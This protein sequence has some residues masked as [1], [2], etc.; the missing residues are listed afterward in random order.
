M[1]CKN[2]SHN[3]TVSTAFACDD[4]YSPHLGV[5]LLS[6]LEHISMDRKYEFIVLDGGI[7]IKN[8]TW[9]E[10]TVDSYRLKGFDVLFT[11]I[12]MQEAF[13]CSYLYSYYT[14]A[15]YYR[16]MLPE[17][18]PMHKK[19]I[20]LDADMVVLTDIAELYDYDLKGKPLGACLDRAGDP[21]IALWFDKKTRSRN[22]IINYVGIK[23]VKNY[24]NSGMLLL[25]LEKI[26]SLNIMDNII[27]DAKE[28][29]YRFPDQDVLNK[30]FYKNVEY[31]DIAWNF[32]N[33]SNPAVKNRRICI[34]HYLEKPWV[35]FKVNYSDLYF[36]YLLK[37]PWYDSI[38]YTALKNYE[39][40]KIY[41]TLIKHW[42]RL[43]PKMQGV[44][45]PFVYFLKVVI[46][47][48]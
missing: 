12:D 18:L 48:H 35:D 41:L 11:C 9:L 44:L 34:V 39:K 36:Q 24:F 13:K 4:N 2:D 47:K 26:R 27:A 30:H 29:T 1:N 42:R 5:L 32:Y 38:Y 10:K 15:I 21:N 22:Y 33:V 31:I 43:H 19:I 17:I 46:K 7:S 45:R 8:K 23:D 37:T 14:T 3:L 6:I 40:N 16:L 20:Y 28:N 25:D